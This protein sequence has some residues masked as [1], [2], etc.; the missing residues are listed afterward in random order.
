MTTDAE[1]AAEEYCK[2]LR[3]HE[4]YE[5]SLNEIYFD[6]LGRKITFKQIFLAGAEWGRLC[7]GESAQKVIYDE[8]MLIAPRWINV[9]RE[10]PERRKLVLI[11]HDVWGIT[12][13]HLSQTSPEIVWRDERGDNIETSSV[14]YWMPLPAVP[15][16]HENDR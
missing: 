3:I 4:D 1:K 16:G 11:Y 8:A 2:T 10:L 14:L 15:E 7:C 13:G 6:E 12:C 5:F 9:E